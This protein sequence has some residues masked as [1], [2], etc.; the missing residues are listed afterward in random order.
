MY[1]YMYVYRVSKNN[2]ILKPITLKSTEMEQ[3]KCRNLFWDRFHK[4]SICAP[5]VTRHTSSRWLSS[6]QN[7]CSMSAVT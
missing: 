3:F 7:G 1:L 4:C 5:I 6:S 2:I